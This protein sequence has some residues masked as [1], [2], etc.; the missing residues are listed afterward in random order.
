VL[1]DLL[2]LVD[3]PNVEGAAFTDVARRVGR[4]DAGVRHRLGRGRFDEQPGLVA[5]LVAPDPP[6]LGVCVSRDHAVKKAPP[7]RT[8]S[9][10][11]QRNTVNQNFP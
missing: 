6:H 11:T 9:L 5:A 10:Q 2:D 1:G 8:Q 4:D 3:A 7:R